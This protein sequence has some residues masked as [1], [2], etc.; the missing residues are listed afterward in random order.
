VVKIGN[1]NSRTAEVLSG[2]SEGA[3]VVLHPS[4]RISD[5]VSVQQRVV[6]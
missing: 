5:A 4:D 2:L 6:Q 3:Q 1:R